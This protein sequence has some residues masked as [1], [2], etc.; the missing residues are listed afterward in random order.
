[1]SENYKARNSE[2]PHF[3]TITIV[4]WIDLLTRP[5]YKDI[6]VNSLRYCAENKGL[7]VH[8]YVVMTN[9]IHTIVSSETEE[10]FTIIRDFKKHT[11]KELVKCLR[12]IPESRRQWLLRAFKE[13]N[14]RIK[15]G[16]K[17]KVWKDGYHPIELHSNEMIDV[18]L[19]YM[20]NN[21]VKAGIVFRQEDY[22][23][24]SAPFYC[25]IEDVSWIQK[26]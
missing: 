17:Y 9:H 10:L 6:I 14:D 7:N 24:S 25:G 3:V 1:M 16:K 15:R 23:Y 4:D 19:E 5:F 8:G 22:V 20:H 11:S 18:R 13:A 12:E 21:P 2:I 26:L